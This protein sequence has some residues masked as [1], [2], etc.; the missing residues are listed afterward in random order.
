MMMYAYVDV[1]FRKDTLIL[2]KKQLCAVWDMPLNISRW[3]LALVKPIRP[4]LVRRRSFSA[5]SAVQ[6]AIDILYGLG[7]LS[8]YDIIG[9]FW[10]IQ[11]LIPWSADT[12]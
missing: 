6:K 12:S 10:P 1:F 4:T 9:C 2:K 5:V 11:R 8:C 3:P 7:D